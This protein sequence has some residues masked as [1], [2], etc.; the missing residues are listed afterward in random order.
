VPSPVEPAPCSCAFKFDVTR[1]ASTTLCG[2]IAPSGSQIALNSANAFTSFA[3]NI[4][5]SSSARA[6]PSPCSPDSEPP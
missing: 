2:F 5:G 3:P 6:W 1:A 4:F